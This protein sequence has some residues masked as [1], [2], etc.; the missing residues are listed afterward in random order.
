MALAGHLA[1]GTKPFKGAAVLDG[2]S[3]LRTAK[4]VYLRTADGLKHIFTSFAVSLSTSSV[5]GSGYSSGPLVL[6]GLVTCNAAGA[7]TPFTYHWT[8]T[9]TGT[10]PITIMNPAAASTRFGGDPDPNTI[11][12][13]TFACTVTDASGQTLTTGDVSVHIRNLSLGGTA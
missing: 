3:V 12:A 13:G 4:D 9:D 5:A 6:T 2:G 7:N 8:R 11:I 1:A 10:D